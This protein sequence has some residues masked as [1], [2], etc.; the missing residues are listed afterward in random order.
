MVVHYD[1]PPLTGGDWGPIF[2]ADNMY[3]TPLSVSLG[4]WTGASSAN[5][6]DSGNWS[7]AV[8]GAIVGTT[9]TDTATFNRLAINSPLTIDAGRNLQHIIFDTAA[10][11]S[12]TIGAAGGAAIQ[13]TAAATIQSTSSVVNPQTV[14]APLILNGDA[15]FTSDASTTNASLNFGGIIEPTAASGLTTI[16]L[17][18]GNNGANTISSMIADN[19]SGLL[20]VTKNGTGS[21][22]L[23]GANAYSGGT[24]VNAGSL[25]FQIAT[26]QAT[27][28]AG[29]TA[30]VASGATVELAGPISAFG[31]AGG[32]RV[33]VINDSLAP[34]VLVSGSHQI[35]AGI[36]GIG[37]VQV[38]AGSDLAANH[39]VQDALVIGGTATSP[40]LVTILASN[41]D[42][43]PMTQSSG[44]ALASSLA[45]SAPFASG[46][47]SASSLLAAVDSSS[48]SSSVGGSSLGTLNFGDSTAAVPEPSTIILL[49][50]GSLAC[51]LSAMRRR[52]RR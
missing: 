24:I 22:T 25:K 45:P 23:T 1:K 37:S 30:V 26:G 19:G 17:D 5:W 28:A 44:F 35:V 43:T 34:G 52:I 12:L 9:N 8:P 4:D 6:A 15:T 29:A 11:N 39:I 27:I 3:V 46:A 7:G 14:N 49:V 36:D 31:I 18:G 13:L 48:G 32:N 50:F 47:L 38:N 16:T 51:L 33:D 42:G 41:P 20:A 10:V 2:M 40:A 21:W